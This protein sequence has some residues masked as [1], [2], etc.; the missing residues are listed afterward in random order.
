MQQLIQTLK[1]AELHIHIEGSLE[2][3]MMMDLAMRNKIQLPYA[4]VSQ[5]ERAYNFENLQSFLDLYY[6]GMSV[7]QTEQ[8][9]Y[10]LMMAY[11]RKVSVQNV[12]RAEIFFDPQGHLPRGV[13]WSTFMLGFERAINDARSELGIDGQLILCFLRH[14]PES[15]ALR[16]FEAAMEYRDLF[17]GVGLDSSELGFPPHLFKNV[18]RQAKDAGLYLSA[19]A[20]EEGPAEYVWEALDI[21]GVDRIDH[22]NNAITDIELVRRIA[23]DK[24]ALTMCPLSNQRLQS[25]PDLSLHQLRDFMDAGVIATINSDDPTYFGGYLNENYIAIAN[26]LKLS[27]IEIRQLAEN[28]LLACYK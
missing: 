10:D 14:L 20:G 5:I 27:E 23:R 21:L 6:R 7:L 8:D 18:F 24:I 4:N 19:H 28:S 26:A 13:A 25:V 22:G 1:K 9:Y 3:Q 16:T 2:P 12:V 15:D 11:L 17:I